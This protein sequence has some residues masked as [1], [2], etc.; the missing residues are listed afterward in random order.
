M[1]TPWLQKQSKLAVYNTSCFHLSS[2]SQKAK[3]LSVIF[4]FSSQVL[5]VWKKLILIFSTV[6]QKNYLR[7]KLLF[8][9][10]L[11]VIN[12]NWKVTHVQLNYNEI[13]N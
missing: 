12:L 3:K 7:H 8:S 9:D 13:H 11:K 5:L 2:S 10:W 4:T 6:L 1:Y